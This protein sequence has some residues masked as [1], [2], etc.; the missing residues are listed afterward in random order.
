MTSPEGTSYVLS[1]AEG[2]EGEQ[3][4]EGSEDKDSNSISESEEF[5]AIQ[6]VCLK[7]ML[8]NMFLG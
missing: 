8:A 4:A 5:K 7:N 3:H 1:H 2:S 6:S